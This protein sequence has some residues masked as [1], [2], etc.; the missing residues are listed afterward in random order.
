MNCILHKISSIIILASRIICIMRIYFIFGAAYYY[1]ELSYCRRVNNFNF[2]QLS[3]FK[4]SYCFMIVKKQL[5]I[6]HLIT[7]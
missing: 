5:I 2:G 7:K 6:I 3:H 1:D 4:L